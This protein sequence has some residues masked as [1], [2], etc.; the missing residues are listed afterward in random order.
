MNYIFYR[1]NFTDENLDEYE[2]TKFRVKIIRDNKEIDKLL[3]NI[4]IKQFLID[5]ISK[6]KHFIKIEL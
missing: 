2:D 1:K 5:R 3:P 6:L 4:A